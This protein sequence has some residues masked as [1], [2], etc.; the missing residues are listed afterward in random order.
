MKLL[1]T[2][3]KSECWKRSPEGFGCSPK[4]PT[5]FSG[6]GA[7]VR[8]C[9]DIKNVEQAPVPCTSECC[10]AGLGGQRRKRNRKCFL[11]EGTLLQ[12]F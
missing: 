6:P 10:S 4:S 1:V 7:V 2:T 3:R 5:A 11:E 8:H 12:E 9:L